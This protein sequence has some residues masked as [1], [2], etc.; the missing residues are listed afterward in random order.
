MHCI[1]SDPEYPMLHLQSVCSAL[2]S[3]DCDG[4]VVTDRH[5]VQVASDL[6]TAV[7]NVSVSQFEHTTEPTEVLYFP[8]TQP[9]HSTP[10][11]PVYPALHRHFAIAPLPSTD[12]VYS[13]QS[14][15]GLLIAA[16]AVEY[17][18][19]KQF[20]HTAGPVVGLNVPA[21]HAAQATFC[22]GIEP[23]TCISLNC[24]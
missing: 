21:T 12:C 5:V 1:P 13:G 18:S 6:F 2:P 17:V 19:A 10:S 3:R 9:A 7:E 14:T 15:H 22:S 8:A 24:M 4:P 20:V 23:A 16:T 11:G